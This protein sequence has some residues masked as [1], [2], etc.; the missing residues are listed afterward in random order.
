MIEI[1]IFAAVIANGLTAG[2]FFTFST[3]VMQALA[4]LDS[5]QGIAAMQM[6][7]VNVINPVV[8]LPF[9]GG[10]VISV[11]ALV[12]AYFQSAELSMGLMFLATLLNVFGLMI[13]GAGNVPL[14]ESLAKVTPQ[15]EEAGSLWKKYL[16]RWTRLNH[17]RT[18]CYLVSCALFLAIR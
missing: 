16:I 1:L 17:Y 8:F 9:L 12:T 18:I 3:F 5:R 6:I 2:I 15:S 10:T 7:N 13:T 11:G 14:N 4:R